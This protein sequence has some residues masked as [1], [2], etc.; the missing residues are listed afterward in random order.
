[1][2]TRRLGRLG[3][4]VGEVGYG[5]W[6]VG[7][8]EGGW[9]GADDGES[10]ASLE[11]AVELGCNFFDT[12]WIYGRGHSEV[13]LSKLTERNS[14]TRLYVATKVPPKDRNWPSTRSS[15]LSDVFPP[16]HIEEYVEKSRRNLRMDRIDLLQFHVWEDSW[17][18]DASWQRVVESLKSRGIIEAVGISVNRWE[19][20]NVLDTLRTGLIDAVQV[21]YNVFDQAPEDV[22]FAVCRELD[23]GVIARVPF[24]EGTLTGALTRTTT[25]PVGDWRSSYFVP[26]NLGQSVDRAD[27]L[28]RIV[29]PGWSLPELALRF[30]L[31]C[32]NVHCVIPGMRRVAHVQ[33]N[34]AVSDGR[35]LPDPLMQELRRHRWDRTPTAWSQ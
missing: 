3:W 17:A 4:N 15:R 24:D 8:G 11:K 26:E 20:W 28:K 7:G 12:A 32:Q 31:E 27:A 33:S 22:L 6:G 9:T 2:R 21:I 30:I 35:R 18:A 14:R 13:L 1:M 34:M 23:I 25:W 10:I 16:E 19:P 5:M 29:P